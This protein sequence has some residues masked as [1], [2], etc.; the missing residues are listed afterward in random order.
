MFI[1]VC[2]ANP[3][4]AGFSEYFLM[5]VDLHRYKNGQKEGK[6]WGPWPGSSLHY[7]EVM[8]SPRWEDFD[9]EYLSA[10]RFSFLGNGRAKIEEEEGADLAYYLSEPGVAQVNGIKGRK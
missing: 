2:L 6:V 7:L 5:A 10:N 4:P 9:I 1:L 8:S 3:P